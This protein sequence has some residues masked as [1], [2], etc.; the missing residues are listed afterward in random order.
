MNKLKDKSSVVKIDS[1]LFRQI[2]DFIRKGENRLKFVNKKQFIDIAVN[3]FLRQQAYPLS[4]A[5]KIKKV[6]K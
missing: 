4:R 2:E 6:N 1:I 5:K 3:D